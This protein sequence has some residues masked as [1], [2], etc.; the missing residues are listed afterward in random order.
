MGPS[1][2]RRMSEPSEVRRQAGRPSLGG[3]SWWK[4]WSRDARDDVFPR[5]TCILY[6]GND[7]EM[8]LA[9]VEGA[10]TES[11]SRW[12]LYSPLGH[13]SSVPRGIW[14]GPFYTSPFAGENWGRECIL[15]PRPPSEWLAERDGPKRLLSPDTILPKWPQQHHPLC[16]FHGQ[17]STLSAL[18]RRNQGCV[19]FLLT[20]WLFK[21]VL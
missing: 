5:G 16:A 17:S 9:Q 13:C 1:G 4:E 21:T 20:H 19:C 11:P 3:T 7:V 14:E 6:M 12:P 2:V 10:V 18:E 15:G 8:K